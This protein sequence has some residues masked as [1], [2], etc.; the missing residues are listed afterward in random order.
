MPTLRSQCFFGESPIPHIPLAN[1]ILVC[2]LLT[3]LLMGRW[4]EMMGIP[5]DKQELVAELCHQINSPLAAMRNAVYLASSRTDDPALLHYLALANEEITTVA[6]ILREAR[7]L[8]ESRGAP[9][10]GEA[11]GAAFSR[12][13]SRAASAPAEGKAA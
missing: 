5:S 10:P 3:N 13:M 7:S 6:I 1:P 11:E 2:E 12:C 4:R 9:V 8:V